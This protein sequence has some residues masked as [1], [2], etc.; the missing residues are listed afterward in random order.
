MVA[1]VE[2]IEVL[3]SRSKVFGVIPKTAVIEEEIFL[4]AGL[5]ARI[6]VNDDT[7]GAFVGGH[8]KC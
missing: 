3:E 4:S 7:G 2:V 8:W 6:A 5:I 1:N